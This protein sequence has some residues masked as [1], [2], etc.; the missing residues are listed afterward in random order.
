MDRPSFVA[1]VRHGPL[2]A[3]LLAL[4]A[5]SGIVD[6]ISILSVG[7]VFVANMTGNIVFVGFALAGVPG[8]SLSASIIA[9]AGF[10]VG[11]VFGGRMIDRYGGSRPVLLR[12][13]VAV[14]IVLV[15]VCLTISLLVH[16]RQG[17]PVAA[18]V[19]AGLVAMA[20]GLQTATARR[21][22]VPDMT[23]S[24][25]T[26]T[27]TGFASDHRNAT[28][29]DFRRAAVI[30]S[31]LLGALAGAILTLNFGSH[32]GYVAVLV[33]LVA[34]AVTT[35]VLGRREAPWHA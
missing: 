22:G 6:A 15:G 18:T 12:N 13:A 20:M 16:L 26:M 27:L 31:M 14:E 34:V 1:D 8:F 10:V 23:T 17:G 4:T 35:T 32:A 25:V 24:V 19:V 29:A 9:L 30:V 28:E 7:H 21:I 5:V 2:P 3:L 11:A 33:V